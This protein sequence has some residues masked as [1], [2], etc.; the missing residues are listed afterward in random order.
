MKTALCLTFLFVSN[1]AAQEFLP[2]SD[3]QLMAISLS[4]L[5]ESKKIMSSG[6]DKNCESQ[7]KSQDKQ[8]V[9][10]APE[11][12]EVFCLCELENLVTEDKSLLAS[13]L[14]EPVSS[15]L[16]LSTGNDNFLHG[17]LQRGRFMRHDGDDRGRTF[18]AAADYQLLGKN[19][20]FSL[21]LETTGFGK[22]SP[23]AEEYKTKEGKYY[24]NFHEVNT[25]DLRLDGNITSGATG[26]SYWISKFKLTNETDEGNLSR[27]VQEWW[28]DFTKKELGVKSIQYEYLTEEKDRNTIGLMGGIGREWI[29]NI[30]NWKC[31]SRTEVTGGMSSDFKGANSPEIAAHAS[32]KITH[33]SVPWLVLSSWIERSSGFMGTSTDGGM[34]VSAEGKMK[35]VTIRPF[36]G[37]ERHRSAMDE[38]YGDADGY[39]Y[40]NYHVLG[41]TIK[42]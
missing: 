30:G 31:Q 11:A 15:E 39:S 37:V 3:E 9:P 1:L 29:K 21:G 32:G 19:G 18:S 26:K 40:E 25:L 2:A 5:D 27:G 20:E 36:I 24:L 10:V 13:L 28:H 12:K 23:L 33:S 17:A 4:Y 7:E 38:K 8:V 6:P 22:F 16:T 34:S 14:S 35:G 42:Y 41:V